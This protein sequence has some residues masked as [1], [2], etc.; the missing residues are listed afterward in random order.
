MFR[1]GIL[2]NVIISCYFASS[3]AA[4]GFMIGPVDCASKQI[5]GFIRNYD[6]ISTNIDTLRSP[7]RNGQCRGAPPQSAISYSNT[8]TCV[9]LAISDNANHIGPCSLEFIGQSGN[10]INLGT[11]SQCLA[12]GETDCNVPNLVTGDMCKYNLEFTGF[13]SNEPGYLR[14]TWTATHIG[15]PYEEYENC[16]DING[17][18]QTTTQVPSTRGTPTQTTTQVPNTRGTPIQTSTREQ[19]T[20]PSSTPI[21]FLHKRPRPYT[22]VC[23]INGSLKCDNGAF[24]TCD[25]NKWIRRECAPGTICK[26]ISNS[27]V[28]DYP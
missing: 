21:K 5:L 27:I 25:N 10:V 7:N 2:L 3:V 28:C 26:E 24:L 20:V 12:G 18:T 13:S 19:N 14:W 8:N 15:P 22:Q 9:A 6:A 4:H 17:G 11:K 16:I 23:S 1:I